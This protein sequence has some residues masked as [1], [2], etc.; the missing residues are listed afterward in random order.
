MA[1]LYGNG[2]FFKRLNIVIIGEI[3]DKLP[4]W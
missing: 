1:R 2:S 4:V 3:K